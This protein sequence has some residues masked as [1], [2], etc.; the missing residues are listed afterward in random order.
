MFCS[1]ICVTNFV[2]KEINKM[3]IQNIK[4]L[5]FERY[6]FHE[7]ILKETLQKHYISKDFILK[8]GDVKIKLKSTDSLKDIIR[9]INLK[10]Y[11]TGIYATTIKGTL[12]LECITIRNS[13]R[14]AITLPRKYLGELASV[15]ANQIIADYLASL[16]PKINAETQA[17]MATNHQTIQTNISDDIIAPDEPSQEV[18]DNAPQENLGPSANNSLSL[19]N[20]EVNDDVASQENLGFDH[21]NNICLL[22]EEANDDAPQENLSSNTNNSLSLLNEENEES[23]SNNNTGPIQALNNPNNQPTA[24]I[25]QSIIEDINNLTTVNCINYWNGLKN[26]QRHLIELS[27]KQKINNF[28]LKYINIATPKEY[29]VSD[30][31]AFCIKQITSGKMTPFHSGN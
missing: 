23:S 10:T 8:L 30:R 12:V 29:N 19:L 3:N 31:F 21:D 14:T 2:K 22:N 15:D 1:A 26:N 6:V 24:I 18:N 17:E 28:Q 27:M 16:P 13:H 9:K 5:A 20:E 4:S 11:M 25:P 7:P